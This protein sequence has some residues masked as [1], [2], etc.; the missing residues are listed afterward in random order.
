MNEWVERMDGWMDAYMPGFFV[1][2]LEKKRIRNHNQTKV[3]YYHHHH[4]LLVKS[5]KNKVAKQK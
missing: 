5:K 4:Y 1:D 2:S 3:F